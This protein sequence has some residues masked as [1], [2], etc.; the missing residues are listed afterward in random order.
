MEYWAIM[1]CWPY[2]CF[3]YSALVGLQFMDTFPYALLVIWPLLV[4][5]LIQFV[6]QAAS[7]RLIAAIV[8]GC[9]LTLFDMLLDPV[10]VQQ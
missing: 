4:I 5:G 2:G 6:P 9:F 1:T 7:N 3:E 8:G 10:A